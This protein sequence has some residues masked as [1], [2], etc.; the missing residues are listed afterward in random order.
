M[1]IRS[2]IHYNYCISMIGKLKWTACKASH[3]GSKQW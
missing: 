3:C 1:S 2:V